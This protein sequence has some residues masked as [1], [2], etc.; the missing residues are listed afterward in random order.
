MCNDT[1]PPMKRKSIESS[2]NQSKKTSLRKEKL[3]EIIKM[4]KKKTFCKMI[5]KL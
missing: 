3:K 4:K 1:K 2:R 5:E